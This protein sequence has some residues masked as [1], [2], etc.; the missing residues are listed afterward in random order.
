MKG[1]IIG[2]FLFYY[3]LSISEAFGFPM[4]NDSC[5]SKS[6]WN[7][8]D[9]CS[10]EHS[11]TSWLNDGVPSKHQWEIHL[12]RWNFPFDSSIVLNQ[13]FH[14]AQSL[15]SSGKLD[16]A[17]DRYK[18]MLHSRAV[19]PMAVAGI[20]RRLGSAYQ[21][22]GQFNLALNAY[23]NAF[24]LSEAENDSSAICAVYLD[25][26]FVYL[27]FQD[28]GRIS[29]LLENAEKFG[30]KRR[31]QFWDQQVALAKGQCLMLNR[32]F[33]QASKLL[34]TVAF[35][36]TIDNASL[37]KIRASISYAANGTLQ[38]NIESKSL[39][40]EILSRCR[41]LNDRYHEALTLLILGNL[42]L[43]RQNYH[44]ALLYLNQ[45][46]SI[47]T[48]DG[49]NAIM[50]DLYQGYIEIASATDDNASLLQYLS[51]YI[52][53]SA[54]VYGDR[55]LI[56][57]SYQIAEFETRDKL[58]LIEDQKQHMRLQERIIEQ[59]RASNISIGVAVSLLCLIVF[60]LKK[61]LTRRKALNGD[62]RWLVHLKTKELE[63]NETALEK[64]FIELKVELEVLLNQL[65]AKLSTTKGLLYLAESSSI[66]ISE[67][68]KTK[69]FY[70][71]RELQEEAHSIRKLLLEISE[72]RLNTSTGGV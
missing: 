28:T 21:K 49:Y 4:L 18:K 38:G 55:Q 51:L 14:S 70:L 31:I 22:M 68:E 40:T 56:E 7:R 26:A 63:E 72:I 15:L 10:S 1:N 43:T 36:C 23:H 3:F 9:I 25:L 52:D 46:F 44:D 27:N 71:V 53:H 69:T 35:D 39:L 6:L 17:I 59:K 16:W 45:C 37:L 47:C 13:T 50:L 54:S 19:N 11:L 48:K 5:G 42:E 64:K 8:P 33:Y 66:E 12:V 57:T 24:A 60:I 20:W 61:M 67:H 2:W 34:R 29:Q 41:A 62:L 30:A 65:H 32:Q 58:S